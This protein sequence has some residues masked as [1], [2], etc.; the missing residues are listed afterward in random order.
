MVLCI[1]NV[2][3]SFLCLMHVSMPREVPGQGKAFSTLFALIRLASGMH[4]FVKCQRF[5]CFECFGTKFTRKRF[6]GGMNLAVV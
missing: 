4:M 5:S 1:A 2:A 3:K 6:F